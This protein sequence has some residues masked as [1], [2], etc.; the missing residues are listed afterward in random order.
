MLA[1]PVLYGLT[2]RPLL[3]VQHENVVYEDGDRGHIQRMLRCCAALCRIIVPTAPGNSRP[4]V[5][6]GFLAAVEHQGIIY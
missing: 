1:P 2:V 4:H 5:G 6:N 3:P